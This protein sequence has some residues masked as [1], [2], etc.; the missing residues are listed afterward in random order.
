MINGAINFPKVINSDIV[1][2]WSTRSISNTRDGEPLGGGMGKIRPYPN[3]F[4]VILGNIS[5]LIKCIKIIITNT[6]CLSPEMKERQD[7][8]IS[9]SPMRDTIVH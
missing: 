3:S 1:V 5:I 2:K 6:D 4:I 8:E 9:R 7:S